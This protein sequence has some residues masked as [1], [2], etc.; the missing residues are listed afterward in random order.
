[1][2]SIFIVAMFFLFTFSVW[3][4]KF[5][6]TFDGGNLETWQ[7]FNMD[8]A[9]PGSWEI[10]DGELQGINLGGGARFLTTGD[11]TWQDYSIEV[12][13]MPLKQHGP[14]FIGLLA[15]FQ[16]TRSLWCVI[17]DS[18]FVENESK[19]TCLGG[20]LKKN[21]W[22]LL[23]T[24]PHPFLRLNKWSRLKLSVKGDV[25]IFLINGKKIVET[26]KAF[27]FIH[28]VEKLMLNAGDIS[29]F[30]I[31]GAGFGLTNYAAKF[32]NITIVGEGI[33]NHDL[34]SVNPW[35]KLTTRWGSLKQF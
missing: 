24:E 10:V 20:G 6:E 8:D 22:E 21:R 12:D 15:R 17:G 4:G 34:L 32:D 9:I 26:G 23:Y 35:A 25:F 29:D 16:D 30:P 7:E 14:G 27:I 1:M 11:E 18:P 2:K 19:I 3:G 33:P 28:D 5:L 31:G 13:V